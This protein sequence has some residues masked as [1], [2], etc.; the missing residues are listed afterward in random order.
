MI[1]LGIDTSCDDTS[2]AILEDRRVLA[3]IISS[4]DEVHQEYGGVFPILAKRAHEQN[5]APVLQEALQ[6]AGLTPQD[7]DVIAVT[8]GP[9]LAPSLEVGVTKAQ[10]LAKEWNT[11][12][13]LIHHMEGHLLSALA[14]DKD[15]TENLEPNAVEFP[16]LG[17]LASG[18][19]TEMVLIHAWGQYEV[20]GE[21]VDDALGEAYDKVARMLG[22]GFPGGAK[23]A[24]LADQG[25][26]NT[27]PLPVAMLQSGDFNVSY[28]GIKTA[29]MNLIKKLTDNN[30][31]PLTE[32]EIQDI[33]ASFQEAAL[34]TL[35]KKIEKVLEKYPV[36]Q[37]LLGGG[38]AANTV[39]RER[40]T[41]LLSP[42]EATLSWP[43]SLR[44]CQDNGAMIA[45]AGFMHH[46]W[47]Y[48]L[49]TNTVDRR[50]QWRLDDFSHSL[51]STSEQ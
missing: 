4:Q 17:V 12:L 7:I 37:V 19:H 5:F 45:V 31:R 16:A 21:T 49:D 44:L 40:L 51:T 26:K 14:T 8:I 11:P 20:I 48:H 36:K 9:G 25:N 27:Y 35:L 23:V 42:T 39:L 24:K 15:G 29:V 1:I 41:K 13:E 46:S 10:E 2:I 30:A 28:S 18:G 38:V 33:S 34:K 50:P 47:N 6:T 22:L 3:N 32:T 43:Y